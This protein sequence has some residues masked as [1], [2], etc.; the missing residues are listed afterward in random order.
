M[1]FFQIGL[2]L[3]IAIATS[4]VKATTTLEK[5]LAEYKRI[6]TSVSWFEVIKLPNQIYAF[7]EPGHSEQVNSFLIVGDKKD[8]LYDT[9]MGIASIKQAIMEVRTTEGLPLHEIVVLNSHGHLDHIGGDFEF[10][11]ITA[12]D[13]PWRIEK[14]MEGIPAGDS[15]WVDYYNALTGKPKAPKSF[16]PKTFFIPKISRDKITLLQKDEVIDLGNRQFEIIN[17]QSHT[18]DSVVLYERNEKILFTGDT[19]VPGYFYV[20]DFDELE[21]DL[22]ALSKLDVS[23]HYNTHGKQLIDLFLRKNTLEAVIKINNGEVSA[24]EHEMFGEKVKVY[25]IDEMYFF[26]LPNFLMY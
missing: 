26:S 13:N 25:E 5:Q 3:S 21:L 22:K 14:L 24:K 20:L 4:S 12:L 16:D 1:N 6:P 23:Y 8:L 17:M 19:F 18:K 15:M 9:G 7:Y 2:L 11:K 10:D